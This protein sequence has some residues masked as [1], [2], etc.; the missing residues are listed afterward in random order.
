MAIKDELTKRIEKA[1]DAI[2]FKG[3]FAGD[4][5][6]T[7]KGEVKSTLEA[8]LPTDEDL[9]I[10]QPRPFLGDI[11]KEYEDIYFK[12]MYYYIG[13]EKSSIR[14]KSYAGQGRALRLLLVNEGRNVHTIQLLNFTGWADY[15][16]PMTI[17]MN[18]VNYGSLFFSIEKTKS[19]YRIARKKVFARAEVGNPDFKPTSVHGDIHIGGDKFYIGTRRRGI[20]GSEKWEMAALT[21]LLEKENVGES[22]KFEYD[23]FLPLRLPLAPDQL[24]DVLSRKVNTFSRHYR[25]EHG[26]G[27]HTYRL[28]EVKKA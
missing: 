27:R 23:S 22:L 5:R 7:L 25:L 3:R 13:N 19:G 12:G 21:M 10:R 17:L 26:E 11:D 9:R 24:M 14:G 18:Y 28:T 15:H 2:S 20:Y 6:E 8:H 4:L 1:I 16:T